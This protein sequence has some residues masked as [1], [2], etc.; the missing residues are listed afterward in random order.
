M[1]T[2]PNGCWTSSNEEGTIFCENQFVNGTF[3]VNEFVIRNN[4]TGTQRSIW[5]IDRV[6]ADEGAGNE[7]D[8]HVANIRQVHKLICEVLPKVKVV[9][10]IKLNLVEDAA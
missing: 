8:N 6:L 5:R 4:N 7:S 10:D 1:P 9:K 2:R 3:T